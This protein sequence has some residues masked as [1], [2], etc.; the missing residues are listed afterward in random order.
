[1]RKRKVLTGRSIKNRVNPFNS[2]LSVSVCEKTGKPLTINRLLP[3]GYY[4][5]VFSMNPHPKP[6][7][8]A[9]LIALSAL[10]AAQTI[11]LYTDPPGMEV[12]ADGEYVGTGPA[13]LTGPFVGPVN[14]VVRDYSAE[15]TTTI[16]TEPGVDYELVITCGPDKGRGWFDWCSFGLGLAAPFGVLMITVAVMGIVS[17][18]SN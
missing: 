4:R 12:W 11:T 14:I 16:E 1:M 10:P 5:N 8:I 15:Y 9:L 2:R 18:V 6:L 17:A 13:G 7:V 3:I